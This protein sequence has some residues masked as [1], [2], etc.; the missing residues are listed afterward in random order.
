VPRE[1]S[2]RLASLSSPARRAAP[3]PYQA[4]VS[5]ALRRRLVAGVLVVASLAMIT[6]YFRETD[7]GVMHEVQN[8]G[9]SVLQ[10]FEVGADRVVAP[11][12]DAWGYVSG[13]IDAKSEADRLRKERD[14]LRA[15]SFQFADAV[16]RR[17]ELEALL[18]YQRS[19]RFPDDYESINAEVV[20]DPL[21]RFRQHIVIA[22]GY[23]AGVRKDYPVVASSGLVGVV[24]KVT[25][26]LSRVTLITDPNNAVTSLDVKT[27]AHGSIRGRGA[28]KPLLFDRV[29]K[30]QSV[31]VG[32]SVVTSG[33][34]YLGLPSLYPK[35]IGIGKVT[36]VIH[37]STELYKSIQVDPF[38]D[39]SRLGSVLVLVPK[40][41]V[42]QLPQDDAR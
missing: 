2:V 13:L 6:A 42:S 10:P 32:H 9:A 34:R 4:R 31:R 16:R 30:A 7:D 8:I 22:A 14:A 40:Q 29:P 20:S 25:R 41:P 28:E 36:S 11:F 26:K 18:A 33:R 5:G 37:H 19:P 24:S 12:R 1:R 23:D 39:F 38:I 35:N 17:N 27:G 15:Q 21:N 3:K